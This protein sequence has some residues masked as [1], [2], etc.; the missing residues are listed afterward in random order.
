MPQSLSQV[1]VHVIY[2][3]KHRQNCLDVATQVELFAYTAAV[4]RN[5]GAIPIKIGG[6]SDHVHLLYNEPRTQSLSKT[7]EVTKSSTSSWLKSRGGL[8]SDFAWQGGYGAFGVSHKEVPAAMQYIENQQEHHR[9]INF[10]DELRKLLS[11]NGIE[12][13]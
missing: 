5:L 12:F 4:L 8:L 6:H 9:T 7:M 2:S 1:T 13:D 3:T 10:Q 11:E